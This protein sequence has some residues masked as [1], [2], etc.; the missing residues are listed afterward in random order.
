M[1]DG[2]WKIADGKPTL[3]TYGRFLAQGKVHAQQTAGLESGQLQP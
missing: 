1:A 3:S 2:K